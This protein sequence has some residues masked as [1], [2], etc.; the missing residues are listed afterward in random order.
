MIVSGVKDVDTD[1]TV[2]QWEFMIQAGSE[3]EAEGYY[4]LSS[5]ELF[6]KFDLLGRYDV[7][8]RMTNSKTLLSEFQ[9][10]TAGVSYRFNAQN[11]LDLNYAF[12]S[13]K[14][15]YNRAANDLLDS[16]VGNL[17]SLQYTIV[18]K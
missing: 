6:E 1:P 7:Y 16:A 9:T 10:I 3:N 13:I 2:N 17:I 15:P 8:N 5:Y 14:A 18:A 4:L 12:N 11:R